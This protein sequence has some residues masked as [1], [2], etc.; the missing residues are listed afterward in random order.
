ANEIH[1]APRKAKLRRDR[2]VVGQPTLAQD[3]SQ[4][5]GNPR[6][7]L[8]RLNIRLLHFPDN[9]QL[10]GAGLGGEIHRRRLKSFQLLALEVA[11]VQLEAALN[12]IERTVNVGL[13]GDHAADAGFDPD[14]L[15]E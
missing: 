1:R 2:R 15:E 10:A 13:D 11:R 6:G 7:Q 3:I 12:L 8:D 9:V 4:I 5:E 14:V